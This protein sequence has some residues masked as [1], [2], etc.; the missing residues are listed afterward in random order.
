M[1]SNK[2]IH[3]LATLL[4]AAIA[5]SPVALLAQA[6]PGTS[7]AMTASTSATTDDRATR[8]EHHD[9]GWIGL[10]GLLGLAGLMR[11]R[12]DVH[13]HDTTASRTGVRP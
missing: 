5:L 1:R 12:N 9:Y 7:P 10:L 2:K 8:E 3:V 6:S 11:K 4:C 13:R